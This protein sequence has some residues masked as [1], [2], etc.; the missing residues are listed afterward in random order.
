MLLTVI[1]VVGR[2][3]I[4]CVVVDRIGKSKEPWCLLLFETSEPSQVTF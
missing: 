4:I 1:L 3:N 2:D